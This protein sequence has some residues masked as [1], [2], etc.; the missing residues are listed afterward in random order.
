MTFPITARSFNVKRL[1]VL[2]FVF[3]LMAAPVLAQESTPAV[4]SPA[5]QQQLNQIEA[6]TAQLRQLKAQH[7]VERHFPSRQEVT[8]YVARSLS[9]QLTAET[10]QQEKQFYHAFGF[11]PADIDLQKIYGNLLSEQIAG[12]YN[13]E[14]KQMNVLMIGG[15]QLG[16]QLPLLEQVVYAHEYTHALQDQ[17]FNLGKIISDGMNT[18]EPDQM[19]AVQSLYE[20]DATLSMQ[21]YLQDALQKNPS[22]AFGILLQSL[23]LSAISIPEGTPPFLVTELMFPY[24]TGL[25]FVTALH[26]AGGWAKI[27]QA[28]TKLPVSTEQIMHPDKYLSGEAPQT[29]TLK[30]DTVEANWKLL[31]SRTLGEFYLR[32]YL[33]TEIPGSDASKAAAGW[34]GDQFHLYYDA[35]SDEVAWVMKLTWDTPADATE[36]AATYRQFGKA[37]YGKDS[38][39]LCWLD[40]SSA[41]CFADDDRTTLVASAPTQAL[42]EA[43]L[44]GQQ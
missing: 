27:D 44:K 7:P 26:N 37:K 10:L 23:S 17:N 32:S 38:T 8:D 33:A 24:E 4:I 13:P 5:L 42:A 21:F 14:T 41:T 1:F 36:F 30:D 34:G 25:S 18:H 11:L 29:V 19:L 28:F 9:T 12:F 6:I 20:G 2:V 40:A 43:L 16:D 3:S 35:A 15:K 31:I 39:A 22:A